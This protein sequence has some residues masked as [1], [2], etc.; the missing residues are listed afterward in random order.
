[1]AVELR[2][3]LSRMV[4][5]PLPSTL[6]STIRRWRRLRDTC[7]GRR[8]PG[9]I[10]HR[11]RRTRTGPGDALGELPKTRRSPYC[12]RKL[13]GCR[14]DR[15]REN[16]ERKNQGGRDER[17]SRIPSQGSAPA[18][19]GTSLQVESSSA[20]RQI[21]SRSSDGGCV[22][23]VGCTVQAISGP[24]L[25]EKRD[26]VTEIPLDRWSTTG[27]TI[28]T[29]RPGEDVHAFR[30]FLDGVDRFDARFFGISPLDS[31]LD[32]PAAAPAAGGLLGGRWRT[33]VR[34]G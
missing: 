33:R 8:R 2:N 23:R 32:R 17:G 19:T 24:L 12:G 15:G 7:P 29:R 18:H 10:R 22:F 3:A 6:L 13:S 9:G 27:S 25:S 4:G 20:E 28:P 14:D 30:A 26:A 11:S 34:R 1:M 5:N 21:P 31:R 16:D